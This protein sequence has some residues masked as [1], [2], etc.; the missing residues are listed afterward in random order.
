MKKIRV[1]T[2]STLLCANAFAADAQSVAPPR[3][4]VFITIDAM[5][6]DY[7]SRFDRQLT[8]GL[9]MLYRG[10]AF[11]TNGFQDHGITETAPGHSATMSGRFPVHTGIV[12]NTAGVNDSTS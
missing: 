5:R 10:G 8:G 6:P 9:G 2:L 4:V 3:L 1:I 12:A 7:F 11:F